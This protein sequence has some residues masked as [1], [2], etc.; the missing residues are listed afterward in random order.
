M[1]PK[2]IRREKIHQRIHILRIRYDRCIIFSLIL[3][4]VGLAVCMG[5]MFQEMHLSGVPAVVDSYGSVLLRD[6]ADLY[7]I[8]AVAAFVAGAILRWYVSGYRIRNQTKRRKYEIRRIRGEMYEVPENKICISESPRRNTYFNSSIRVIRSADN[9]G[10]FNVSVLYRYDGDGTET[11]NRVGIRS[12]I[13]NDKKY[14][15]IHDGSVTDRVDRTT[16]LHFYRPYSKVGMK[17][18]VEQTV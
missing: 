2:E 7:V 8:I 12:V 11:K 1:N 4:S 3:L 16:R 17:Q 14:F 18:M 6:G 10:G 15:D 9:T 5:I 13:I